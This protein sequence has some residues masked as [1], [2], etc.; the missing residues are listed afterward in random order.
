[1][2]EYT[3]TT[4]FSEAIFAAKSLNV[5]MYAN[6]SWNYPLIA[7]IIYECCTSRT[8]FWMRNYFKLYMQFVVI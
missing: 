5:L 2:L 1:M 7:L 6:L 3:L 4:S 8:H